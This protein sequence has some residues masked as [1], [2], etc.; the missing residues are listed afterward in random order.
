MIAV[1]INTR[2]LF[3]PQTFMVYDLAG[4]VLVAVDRGGIDHSHVP[5]GAQSREGGRQRYHYN[6]ASA[7]VQM[8]TGEHGKGVREARA[9]FWRRWNLPWLLKNEK[10]SARSSGRRRSFQLNRTT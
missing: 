6:R 9:F 5:R 1:K 3:I 7:E 10:G 8:H 2:L 4:I